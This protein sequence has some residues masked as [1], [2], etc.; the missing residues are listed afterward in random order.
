MTYGFCQNTTDGGLETLTWGDQGLISDSRTP[1]P[2]LLED[3]GIIGSQWA[4]LHALKLYIWV[5]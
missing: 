4:G 3:L 1:E 5:A 2:G